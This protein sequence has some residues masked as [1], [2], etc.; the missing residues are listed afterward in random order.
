MNIH[1]DIDVNNRQVTLCHLFLSCK[2]EE[3]FI[4]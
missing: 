4:V 2:V 1:P 3:K